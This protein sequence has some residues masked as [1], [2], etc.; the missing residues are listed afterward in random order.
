MPAPYTL[1]TLDVKPS[2][3]KPNT[4]NAKMI[5]TIHSKLQKNL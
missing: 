1:L 3:R 5:S 2:V 4:K